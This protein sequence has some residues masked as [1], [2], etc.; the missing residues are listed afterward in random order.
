MGSVFR[1]PDCAAS[2]Q[3]QARPLRKMYENSWK[4]LHF[5]I[6]CGKLS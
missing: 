6:F 4:D 2:A 1:I 3:L 5:L